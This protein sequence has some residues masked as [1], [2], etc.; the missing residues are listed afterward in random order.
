MAPRR[1]EKSQVLKEAHSQSVVSRGSFDAR[2]RGGCGT[3][4]SGRQLP[5]PPP[6]WPSSPS[7][8]NSADSYFLTA[9]SFKRL[10]LPVALAALVVHAEPPPTLTSR[11]TTRLQSFAQD[12]PSSNYTFTVSFYSGFYQFNTRLTTT[13]GFNLLARPKGANIRV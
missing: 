9:M 6:P 12:L 1:C 8:S 4:S 10:L 2:T 11:N 7:Q 5:H 3:I 13:Q